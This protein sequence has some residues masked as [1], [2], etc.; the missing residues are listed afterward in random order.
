MVTAKCLAYFGVRTVLE[1][2][3]MISKGCVAA[4]RSEEFMRE[5]ES[6]KVGELPPLSSETVGSTQQELPMDAL[7]V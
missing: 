6:L 1:L 2:K 3:E 5:V 4:G 7:V